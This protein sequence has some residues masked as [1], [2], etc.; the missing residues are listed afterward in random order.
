VS[1]CRIDGTEEKLGLTID[2]AS[3]ADLGHSRL[4]REMGHDSLG[5]A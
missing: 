4:W 2:G 5:G 1:G 3:A